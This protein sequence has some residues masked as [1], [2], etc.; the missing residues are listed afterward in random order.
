LLND[1]RFA[2]RQ[3]RKNLG[4][5]L[6]AVLTLA[7][8]IGAT[9]TIFSLVNAVL[10]RPLPFPQ[11][12]RLMYVI[13]E[14]HANGTV[15]PNG[16]SYP[17]FFDWRVQNHSFS[18]MACYRDDQFTLMNAGQADTLQTEIVSSEL[19]RVLGIHPML[20][21]DFTLADEKPGEHVVMLSHHLWQSEFGSRPDIVGKAINLNGA[22]YT[23]AGVMPRDFNF[24]I[25]NPE[26]Q[27]WVTL[28]SDAGDRE[29][30]TPATQHRGMDM[31]AVIGRLKPGVTMVQARADM[32]LID[33]NLAAQY[34]DS[35]KRFTSAYVKPEMEELVGDVRPAL[36]ILFAAVCFLLLIACANV[37]G[38]LLARASRRQA[39]IALRAALGATRVE[40]IRQILVESVALSLFGGL[41]G[42]AFSTWFLKLL[43]R[44]VPQSLPRMNDI[45]VDFTVLAFTV[46]AS[47]ITG[48]LFGVLPAWRMSKLDPALTLREGT[49]SVTGSRGQQRLHA[50][51]VIAETALSLVLLIGSGLFIHS[52]VRVLEVNPGFDHRN[53]L[54]ANLDYPYSKEFVPKI[55]QFYG[56]FLPRIAALP[57]VQ[58]AAAGWP[59]PFSDD[60][61]GISFEAEG[62]PVAR[63]DR[64]VASAAIVTPNFFRTLRIPLLRGRDFAVTDAGKAPL[65]AIVSEGFARKYFPGEDALGKHIIPGLDDGV[66]GKGPREIVGI[67]GDV[68]NRSLTKDA[69][70]TF[71]VP[72]AQDV[73]TA[74]ALVI[75][76]ARNPTGVIAPLRAQLNAVDRGIPLYGVHTFDEMLS[77][78][79]SQPRFSMMLL[80]FFAVMAVLLAAVGLY[81]VLSY[82]VTQRTNEM[83]LRLALG[84]QRGDVLRLILERG[85]VLAGIGI[86]LGLAASALVTHYA[87]SLLYGVHA[88]DWPTYVAVTALFLLISLAA[89]AAP[90]VRAANV[91]PGST[92][93]EQ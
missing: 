30:G 85:L 58:S 67:V 65:V 50:A 79:V 20:G 87:A 26:P 82:I 84:A 60:H 77:D 24:P 18:G 70:P 9:T 51:L 59:L 23:V 6:T 89:S 33:R 38:L 37:A 13:H 49:R 45:P 5:T 40:I 55:L 88:F 42:L 57:C 3:L 74:P 90:A 35:N 17:D 73:I 44:F 52:F 32:S 72:F 28:A 68:K 25:E 1:L 14:Y 53:V 71:Y 61:I 27:L 34:P 86:V 54:T 39:E 36:R 63:G 69:P 47:V 75:R 2:L 48:L 22:S 31:L 46:I 41:L 7:L 80:S 93:R 78:A 4:F 56:Q 15:S 83:G 43:P 21:R 92:L 81:A 64:P 76:A 66:H 8:G 11:P 91:D 16:I 12:N 62:H 19:F 29:V 10:L